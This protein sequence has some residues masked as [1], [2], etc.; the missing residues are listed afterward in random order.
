MFG[1]NSGTS[2]HKD[3]D[4][5]GLSHLSAA[6]EGAGVSDDRV[7]S[8]EDYPLGMTNT[9]DLDMSRAVRGVRPEFLTAPYKLVDERVTVSWP[10]KKCKLLEPKKVKNF[11][12]DAMDFDL[13]KTVVD[14]VNPAIVNLCHTSGKWY[15]IE[16]FN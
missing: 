16:R 6:V 14:E 7:P 5:Y 4:P 15:K 13:D 10:F 1:I 9:K 2:L 8:I 11:V 12:Y 3:D